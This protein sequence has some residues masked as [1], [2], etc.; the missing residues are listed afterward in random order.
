MSRENLEVVRAIYDA[1]A[2]RDEEAA[3][4]LY[5]EDIV[6]DVSKSGRAAVLMSSVYRGHEGVRRFWRDG[7]GSS[8]GSILRSAS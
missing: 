2:R 8:A 7:L 5:A 1:A 3:F 6:W 4:A